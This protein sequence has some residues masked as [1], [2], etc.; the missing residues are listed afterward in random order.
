MIEQQL[1]TGRGKVS[2]ALLVRDGKTGKPKFKDIFN[3]PKV[4]WDALTDEEKAEI[5]QQRGMKQ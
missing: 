1:K 4:F 5:E 3:I 2:A